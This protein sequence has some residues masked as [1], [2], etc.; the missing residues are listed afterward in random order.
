MS[1]QRNWFGGQIAEGHKDTRRSFL[2]TNDK[3]PYGDVLGDGTAASL[4]EPTFAVLLIR[5]IGAV[6]FAVAAP[7][8]IDAAAFVTLE[9]VGG[10]DGAVLLVAAV[11][12]LGDAVAAPGHRDAVDL[13]RGAGELLRGAGGRL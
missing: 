4:S 2:T 13:P 1:P 3:V 6:R 7:L 10:A 9:L 5:V 11:G 8:G 12:A